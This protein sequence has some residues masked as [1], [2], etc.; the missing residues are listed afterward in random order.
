MNNRLSG[1]GRVGA[2]R[3]IPL[4]AGAFLL[5]GLAACGKG[6]GGE[7]GVR[8]TPREIIARGWERFEAMDYAAALGDFESA[9]GL[10]ETLSDAWNG[11]GWSA[12]RVTGRL[13][14]AEGYF[15]GCLQRDT[16]RYDAL[17]GWA[18][19]AYQ[20]QNWTGAISKADSLLHRRP[21]WRFLH[22][23]TVD[24]HDLRLMTAAAYYNLG[25]FETALDIIVTYLNPAFEADV[26]TPAG[27]RELLDE[28]ERLRQ[29][30]G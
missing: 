10:N 16:T 14:E 2:L 25:D 12:G 23:P 28:I 21:G 11:A 30:Y 27:R 9:I 19:V 8:L 5:I 17:G 20:L 26:S 7:E 29:V 15:A 3:L 13:G 18:F 6:G 22:Q 24:F 1:F 4:C